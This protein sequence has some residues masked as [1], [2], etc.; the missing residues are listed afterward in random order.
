MQ[1][2]EQREIA[3]RWLDRKEQLAL[4]RAVRRRENKRDIAIIQTLLGTGLRISELAALEISDVATGERSGWLTVRYG[5]GNK[6]RRIP[7]NLQTRRELGAYLEARSEE[8]EESPRLFLGQRGP[9][10]EAGIHY[11]VKKYAYQ[12]QLEDVTTHTLRHSFA[13][14]LVDA[15]VPLDQVAML[16]GHESLDTT[17]IY[18]Q[19]SEQDLELAV[20]KG[21]GELL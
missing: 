9:L 7:L 18:T 16:L 20:R 13:K 8:E 3:P 1:V 14:N 5:K 12:A 21:G 19:P 17:R 2:K 11:L 10:N 4:L 6:A 15:G